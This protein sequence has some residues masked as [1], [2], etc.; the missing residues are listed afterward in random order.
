[1]RITR[2]NCHRQ[3]PL[4]ANSG[5]MLTEHCFAMLVS[6]PEPLNESQLFVPQ[7]L[8]VEFVSTEHG[9]QPLVLMMKKVYNWKY[10]RIVKTCM[11]FT[12]F[13]VKNSKAFFEKNRKA[14]KQGAKDRLEEEDLLSRKEFSELRK[15]LD[16]VE[17]AYVDDYAVK[18]LL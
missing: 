1:M 11:A 18:L 12:N 5:D 9:T 10:P 4:K 3:S 8:L 15:C 13:S 16:T 6:M 2:R 7:E 14:A 17:A